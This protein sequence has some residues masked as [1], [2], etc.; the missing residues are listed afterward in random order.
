M[1]GAGSVVTRDVPCFGLV[2]GNPAVLKGFVCYCGRKLGKVVKK[3]KKKIVYEC[4]HC[5]KKVTIGKEC[6][7]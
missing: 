3:D 6:N 5:G 4:K 1:I 2:F 7:K